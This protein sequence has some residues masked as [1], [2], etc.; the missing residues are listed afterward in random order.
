MWAR[1][2]PPSSLRGADVYVCALRPSGE[3]LTKADVF[4]YMARL[5]RRAGERIDSLADGPFAAIAV[6]G[7]THV[8]PLLARWRQLVGVG[9]VRLDN[10]ADVARLAGLAPAHDGSDLE[11]VLA[12]LD[13]AGE[14]C[15]PRLLGD[16]AFVAW[17]A[18]AQ[19]LLAVRD[20]FGVKPLY[21]RA[22]PGLLLFA[23]ETG[24]LRA[25]DAYDTDYLMS[26]LLAERAGVERTVW[27]DVRA[28]GAGGLVRQ[29]GSVQATERYW[30]AGDFGPADDGDEAANRQAFRGLLEEAV[31]TRVTGAGEVWAQLSGGL[32]SSSV[33]AV[34]QHAGGA[35]LG[36]TITVVDS[37]GEGDERRF[38]DAVVERY[39]LRN[40]QVRDYWAWQDDGEPPPL[41]D[42][43]TPMYPFF[44]RDRRAWNVVRGAGA[45]VLL[46]GMGADHYLYGTLD[47]ITD[48]ASAGRIGEAVREVTTWSVA[49]RRSFWRLG[50]RYLVDPFLPAGLARTGAALPPDWLAPQW[51]G[52]GGTGAGARRPVRPA[53]GQ[54]FA[55]RVAAELESLTGWLERWPYGDDVEMRYPFLHRP[56]VEWSLRL[57]VAQ[58]VRPHARKWIL[59]E[60]TR[61]L[62]PDQVRLRSTKGGIDARILWSLQHEA[63]RI[64]ALLRDPILAQLGCI[65]PAPLRA[66]VEQA[67]RG[68]PVHNV[69]LFSAL[70]LETWL[71][72]RAGRWQVLHRTTESAA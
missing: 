36:G 2:S 55:R 30:R 35:R 52:R 72:V 42:Q 65:E 9:D 28:V 32:D 4:G 57:P 1:R 22:G 67:R 21:Q 18:R 49:T 6:S 25:D 61:D 70:S 71:A 45:R 68:V 8:R 17:D 31:R 12:A 27:R 14:A 38:S 3:R 64:D 29:R 53:A 44:A 34:A 69:H 56:L 48:L 11:L 13:A 43:P 60:A 15:V 5:R 62:L 20:A 19:K 63:R 7:P 16:F 37:L 24:P 41:T 54:R 40:E 47:Y 66:A 23:S 58:R 33:V 10:R 50:R 59:R 39:Q 46:S 26:C 51:G